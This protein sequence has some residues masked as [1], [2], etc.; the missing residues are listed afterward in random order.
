LRLLLVLLSDAFAFRYFLRGATAMSMESRLPSRFPVGT[1]YIVEGEPGQGGTLR[2]VS[3]YVVMPSG[4]RYDL[5]TE[6]VRK[7]GDLARKR[8]PRPERL[9]PSGAR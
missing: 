7:P 3:R 6:R 1:H 8:R 9:S 2:I 4:M 5:P